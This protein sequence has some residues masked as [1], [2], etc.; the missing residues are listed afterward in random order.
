MQNS[1]AKGWVK[2]KEAKFGIIED[3]Q[4]VVGT[5]MM[6]SRMVRTTELVLELWQRQQESPSE[7]LYSNIPTL[8]FVLNDSRSVQVK[9]HCR[10][11]T[12]LVQSGNIVSPWKK[13]TGALFVCDSCG[14]IQLML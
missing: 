10:L 13:I 2:C 14:K 7:Q 9:D 11:L 12:R 6:E 1:K 5:C 3:R 8:L 4:T